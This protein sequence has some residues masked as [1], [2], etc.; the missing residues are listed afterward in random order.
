MIFVQNL[1]LNRNQFKDLI[2]HELIQRYK[3]FIDL[4]DEIIP[5]KQRIF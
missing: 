4:T 5:K 2:Y 1:M 3:T